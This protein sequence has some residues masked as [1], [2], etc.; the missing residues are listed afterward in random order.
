MV[1]LKKISNFTFSLFYNF[2]LISQDHVPTKIQRLTEAASF[3][4]FYSDWDEHC[5][6]INSWNTN[7]IKRI[8]GHFVI[9]N[10]CTHTLHNHFFQLLLIFLIEETTWATARKHL[11]RTWR[12]TLNVSSK[13]STI[14]LQK[15][16]PP[17]GTTAKWI[18]ALHSYS[19]TTDQRNVNLNTH[20]K[21]VRA[22]YTC[23]LVYV[24]HFYPSL[25]IADG[26]VV[27]QTEST[28]NEENRIN[29][30]S[31]RFQHNRKS[32]YET[33][34]E[35]VCTIRSTFKDTRKHSVLFLIV[36]IR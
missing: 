33:T 7:S 21:C 2:L 3:F 13:S 19:F 8:S 1:D 34:H 16:F 36:T 15:L 32:F 26:W 6:T 23:W 30:S 20:K 11:I 10:Y 22:R 24:L 29:G 4:T 31:P 27:Y 35:H 18:S 12:L 25:P 14:L 28:V 17:D 5:S 9:L